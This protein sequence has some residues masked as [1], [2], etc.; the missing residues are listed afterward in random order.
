MTNTDA[1]T[2]FSTY[3]ANLMMLVMCNSIDPNR[4]YQKTYIRG[5]PPFSIRDTAV[6][7]KQEQVKRVISLLTIGDCDTN[8]G[9]KGM[10]AVSECFLLLMMITCS[11]WL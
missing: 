7:G 9:I 8:E 1:A 11:L 4:E 3:S 5:N 6:M 10:G 2:L